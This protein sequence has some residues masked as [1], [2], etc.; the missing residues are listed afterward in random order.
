MRSLD[1]MTFYRTFLAL[2]FT[3]LL[4]GAGGPN[5]FPKAL[6]PLQLWPRGNGLLPAQKVGRNLDRPACPLSTIACPPAK[7][8]RCHSVHTPVLQCYIT[9][10]DRI[11]QTK[12]NSKTAAPTHQ[13]PDTQAQWS[14]PMVASEPQP[15]WERILEAHHLFQLFC[16]SERVFHLKE[17][18]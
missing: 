6:K 18:L 11:F 9:L 7:D 16:F 10:L 4:R 12:S 15:P 13:C 14:L 8:K 17:P 5:P 1:Q 2:T 3:W